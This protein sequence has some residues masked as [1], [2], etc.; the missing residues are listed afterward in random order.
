MDFKRMKSILILSVVFVLS[1]WA[2]TK[3]IAQGQFNYQLNLDGA[4]L[5]DMMKM[6]ING[7]ELSFR[8]DQQFVDVRYS[9]MLASA[10][11][12][13][14]RKSREALMLTELLGDKSA[15]VLPADMVEPRMKKPSDY[16]VQLH[17]ESRMIGTW[18]CQK[19]TVS[20]AQG[21]MEIWYYPE[22]QIPDL[23]SPWTYAEI[24]GLPVSFYS[25]NLNGFEVSLVL[26][27]HQMELDQALTKEIPTGYT[28]QSF[29]EFR[30]K[31]GG[32]IGM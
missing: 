26:T 25:D 27:S 22:I 28:E 21:N 12:V 29:E 6:M 17:E 30:K 23:D 24:P 3:P 16:E 32:Y 18:N 10:Q 4:Q 1:A 2:G 15:V 7:N 5:N 19:A 20:S 31:M 14:N 8:F 13:M 11:V 9:M